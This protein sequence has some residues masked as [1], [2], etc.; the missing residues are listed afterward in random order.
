MKFIF[1]PKVYL[2]GKQVVVRDQLQNFLDN[3]NASGWT[4]DAPSAGEELAEIGGRNCY[5]SWV[6]KREGGNKAYLEHILD[7]G[8]LSVCEHSVYTLLIEGISRSNSHEFVRHRHLSPSQL[9]QRYVDESVGEYVVPPDLKEEVSLA[10]NIKDPEHISKENQSKWLIGDAWI[11]SIENSHQE[12]IKTVEYLQK[13]ASSLELFKNQRSTEK[14][15]FA[16]QAARSLLPN[17]TETKITMTG[18]ARAWRN[19]IELRATR[20]A[21]PEIRI[22]AYKIWQ[23]LVNESPNM[24]GDYKETKLEDGTI[25]L[26][27]EKGKV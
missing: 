27:T 9:S 1:E 22:M 4:T 2:I 10:L 17:A 19:F 12:Y 5:Q 6:N 26:S 11:S 13:K 25:E 15:K 7:V 24:F 8:H 14:R 20:F 18:N 16:R 21:D 23:I 3:N